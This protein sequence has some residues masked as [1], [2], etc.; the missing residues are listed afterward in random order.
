MRAAIIS[1]VHAQPRRPGER[2]STAIDASSRR[3]RGLV[4]RRPGRL[5]PGARG[6]RQPRARPLGDLPGGQ[7]RPGRD[8]VD[9]HARVRARRRHGRPLDARRDDASRR[10]EQLRALTPSG[11]RNGVEL[12]HAS[13]RD[14]VWEYVI[15]DHTA[16]ACLELQGGRLALIGHS[17]VP[18]RRTPTTT[19]GPRRLRRGGHGRSSTSGASCST[20]ARSASPAT[21]TPG[22][23]TCCSI[24]T[25]GTADLAAGRVRHRA[26][27][28]SRSSPP[29]CPASLATRLAAAVSDGSGGAARWARAAEALDAP[30]RPRRSRAP[31]R[32]AT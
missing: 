28:S 8:R 6:V 11:A 23:P 9:Q 20:P 14:P 17:H 5:R 13:I 25:A 27:R 12:Y 4:P 18:L 10:L 2:C 21:A 15:D 7:P 16:A 31:C 29:A 30:A 26:R 22:P 24:S 1:D 3:R 19:G 32:S